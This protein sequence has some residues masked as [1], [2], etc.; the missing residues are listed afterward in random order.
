MARLRTNFRVDLVL[1]VLLLLTITSLRGPWG[2]HATGGP[3]ISAYVHAASGIL[4]TLGVFIHIVLHRRWFG[5]VLAGKTRRRGKARLVLNSCI[6]L[7]AFFACLSGYAEIS[8]PSVN[9]FHHVTGLIALVGMVPHT[10][11]HLR[12]HRR[13]TPSHPRPLQGRP[14][15]VRAMEPRQREGLFPLNEEA[16]R[17]IEKGVIP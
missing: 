3:D 4:L 13:R 6:G 1:V 15:V 14:G 10:V 7:C 16:E 8:S 2:H 5:V 17:R 12:Q 11:R 9:V